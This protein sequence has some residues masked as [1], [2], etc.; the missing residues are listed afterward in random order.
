MPCDVKHRTVERKWE[1]KR[2]REEEERQR[3]EREAIPV[4]DWPKRI[5]K[6]AEAPNG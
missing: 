6:P 3:R 4:P 2:Q 1:K 5:E